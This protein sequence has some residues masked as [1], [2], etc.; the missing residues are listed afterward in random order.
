MYNLKKDSEV[1]ESNNMIKEKENTAYQHSDGRQR[2]LEITREIIVNNRPGCLIISTPHVKRHTHHH[3]LQNTHPH[4]RVH[5][6]LHTHALQHRDWH[7]HSTRHLH[8]H[9]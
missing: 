6:Y 7:S 9:A 2:Q 4:P 1:N 5:W 3:L 8:V